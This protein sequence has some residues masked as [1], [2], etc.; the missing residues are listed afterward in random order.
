[1]KPFEGVAI[2]GTLLDYDAMTACIRA[3]EAKGWSRSASVPCTTSTRRGFPSISRSARG[4]DWCS[5][6]R[7]PVK[8]RVTLPIGLE[9]SDRSEGKAAYKYLGGSKR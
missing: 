7:C 6:L 3:I 4:V 5:H 9:A 8:T 2:H 1:M